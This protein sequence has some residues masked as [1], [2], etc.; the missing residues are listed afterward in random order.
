[1]RNRHTIRSNGSWINHNQSNNDGSRKYGQSAEQPIHWRWVALLRLGYSVLILGQ[2][3]F[4]DRSE[5]NGKGQ[6][7]HPV[8]VSHGCFLFQ[9]GPAGPVP[10]VADVALD[11]DEEC[12]FFSMYSLL[13][14][15]LM[16]L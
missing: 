11:Q 2:D 13:S 10:V 7:H 5:K 3:D 15:P 14:L 12:E 8:K 9:S 6:P 1:M 16:T 4:N